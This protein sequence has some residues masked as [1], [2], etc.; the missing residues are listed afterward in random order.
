MNNWGIFS[1]RV[2][3]G[4]ISAFLPVL[5]GLGAGFDTIFS[6]YAF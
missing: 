2:A 5:G 3:K 1:N 4:V 6:E